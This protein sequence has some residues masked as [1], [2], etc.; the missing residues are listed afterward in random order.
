MP[1]TLLERYRA[2]IRSGEIGRDQ[3]Q[4]LAVEK[5]QLLANRLASYTPPAKTDIFS[6]LH[7]PEAGEVPNGL[8]IF[9]RVGRGKTMLMDLFF[10]T[11]P[12]AKKRRVHFHEFMS[13]THDLI[14]AARKKPFRRS[15]AACR[16]E[17][18]PRGAAALLR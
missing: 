5:L 11:V 1:E 10:A 13:E 12:F 4:A 14:A 17:D 7:P 18:R 6:F 3:A 15:R 9:G 8:Y 2:M 16:R